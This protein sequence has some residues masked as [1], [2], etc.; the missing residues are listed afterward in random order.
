MYYSFIK[1]HIFKL[2]S[3]EQ[4]SVLI[5]FAFCLT[6]L[7]AVGGGIVD[8]SISYLARTRFQ[9]A[10]DSATAQMGV[11]IKAD[12]SSN[13]NMTVDQAVASAKAK[14]LDQFQSTISHVAGVDPKSL[15]YNFDVSVSNN[16]S[17]SAR[18]ITAT[19]SVNAT[20]INHFLG[21][22]GQK[23]TQINIS[24]QASANL[25]TF[26]NVN[27]LVDISQSMAIGGNASSIKKM[28]SN[29][30]MRCMFACHDVSNIHNPSYQFMTINGKPGNNTWN[31]VKCNSDLGITTRLD[32]AKAAIKA[33]LNVLSG[34]QYNKYAATIM[35][36][37]AMQIPSVW[38][39]DSNKNIVEL[40]S[41]KPA[42]EACYDKNQNISYLNYNSGVLID[43]TTNKQLEVKDPKTNVPIK[44]QGSDHFNIPVSNLT[45]IVDLIDIEEQSNIQTI[46]NTANKNLPS[47]GTD[48]DDAL[49]NLAR[50]FQS[51]GI[52]N[53][54]N[55]IGDNA[56]R[57]KQIVIL[58]TDGAQAWGGL[59]K[60]STLHQGEFYSTSPSNPSQL[61]ADQDVPVDIRACTALKNQVTLAIIYV[62]PV[63]ITNNDV[64]PNLA[65]Q[66]PFHVNGLFSPFNY[67]VLM[68]VNN[69][70]PNDINKISITTSQSIGSASSSAPIFSGINVNYFDFM[71]FY[72]VA[73]NFSGNANIPLLKYNTITEKISMQGAGLKIANYKINQNNNKATDYSMNVKTDLINQSN[74]LKLASTDPANSYTYFKTQPPFEKNMR[75]CATSDK[76]FF[77]VD[78]T[79]SLSSADSANQI[80]QAIN[81]ILKTVDQSVVLTR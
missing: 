11:L 51:L 43:S 27:F 15:T 59:V 9:N 60:N 12:L 14:V 31:Y 35:T 22:I 32:N 41:Q 3:H 17:S 70:P 23:T 46:N 24:S 50:T 58:L 25:P 57:A 36:F 18:I 65:T 66:L 72:G 30:N 40:G 63:D 20:I 42:T 33:S 73:Y 47:N 5:I 54:V 21:V 62:P 56:N 13:Q 71:T 80:A 81:A 34:Q 68:N 37:G 75:D 26:I 6:I 53:S 19:A 48:M 39:L 16:T 4:G 29:S 45:Q 77:K 38:S 55:S 44:F 52:N 61:Q 69:T 10:V 67:E 2:K 1:L 7:L 49:Y 79:N 28:L 8:V 64:F 76:Y 74:P 78:T